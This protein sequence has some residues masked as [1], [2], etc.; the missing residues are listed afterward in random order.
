MTRPI[1]T[2]LTDF[3]TSDHYVATMKGVISGICPDASIVDISHEVHP[4]E[5]PQGAY[6]LAQAYACFPPRTVH[7]VVV[8]PGV[9]TS[10]RPIMAEAARQYFVAPDNG[11]LSM[12]Y[13]REPRHKVRAITAERYFRKPVSQ[14]FHGRDIFSPSAAHLAAGVT[15]AKFG[16]LIQDY[17]RGGF[18]R[19]VHTGKRMW[20]GSVLHIDHFGNVVTNFRAD[21]LPAWSFQFVMSP[22]Q[23][24]EQAHSYAGCAP[25]EL[26]WIAGSGGYVEI[27]LNQASAAKLI[28]CG[29]GAPVELV[30]Y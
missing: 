21:D 6:L 28:G 29:V 1:I 13:T 22:Y 2:L 5:I 20:M 14:T 19:P 23:I 25:G 26:F 18:E 11:V 12:I 4:Y 8:D 17:H 30:P 3:G 15:P 27:S 24:Y 7:V 16:K 9:G 10:R